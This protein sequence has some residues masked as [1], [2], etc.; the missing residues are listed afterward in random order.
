MVEKMRA[1]T[2]QQK[3][4]FRDADLTTPEH[5]QIMIWLHNNCKTICDQWCPNWPRETVAWAK[6]WG[7]ALPDWPGVVVDTVQW[8]HPVMSKQFM[9]GFI[10]LRAT[11][12]LPQCH[13]F[14]G[15]IEVT[16]RRSH[17]C[18][19]VKSSIPSLGELV[20]QINMYRAYDDYKEDYFVVVCPDDSWA[21][22]LRTLKI[23]YVKPELLLKIQPILPF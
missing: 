8:E 10:D 18:F 2:L 19:E 11:I 3:F 23:G 13:V 20:R 22:Q 5:D 4:G 15:K 12:S 6:E 1:S 9:V 21:K 7:I 14:D 16:T 17:I